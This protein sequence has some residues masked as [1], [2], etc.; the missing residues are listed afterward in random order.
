MNIQAAT[1]QL[2]PFFR[3]PIKDFQARSRFIAG[4]ALMLGGFIVPI[5]PGLLAYGYALRI[6]RATAEGEP[7]SM[8]PW[9]D[10][11]SL[12]SLG[13]RGAIISLVFMLP[14]L[15]VILLGLAVYFGTFFLIPLTSGAEAYESDPILVLLFLA[16]GAMFFSMAIGS[17]LL[18]LGSIPLPASIAHF[19][20]KDQLS[21]AFKVR[22]WWP[23]LSA[24][25]LAYFISFVIVAG[26]LGIAY[27]A[28]FVL[29]S[30]L[31]LL[32]VAFFLLAPLGFYTMLVA[33]SLFGETYREGSRLLQNHP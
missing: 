18:I 9:D 10:W 4:S 6:M 12:L 30:T 29:Y 31:I 1:T 27:Y 24:N 17:I 7:P 16:L 26:I 23:I 20:T 28:F 8:P 3:F 11:T 22:E 32:C 19:V 33:A 25:R 15:S 5:L 21:A 13:L 2:K 14:A